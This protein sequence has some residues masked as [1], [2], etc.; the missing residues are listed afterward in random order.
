M[1]GYEK[2]RSGP[3]QA[4]GLSSSPDFGI[5]RALNQQKSSVLLITTRKSIY[6]PGRYN[7][8]K[9]SHGATIVSARF[10][11]ALCRFPWS[12]GSASMP[13]ILK[14]LDFFLNGTQ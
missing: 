6:S 10:S 12:S 7:R 4:Q 8:K 13:P 3:L 1:H 2:R 9:P 5:I 14:F 11:V